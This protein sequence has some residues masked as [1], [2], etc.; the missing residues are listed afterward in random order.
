MARRVTATRR[1]ADGQEERDEWV[2]REARYDLFLNGERLLG[3]N[4]LPCDLE[5]YVIGFLANEGILECPYYLDLAIDPQAGRIE[6]RGPFLKSAVRDFQA[7]RTL[8]SG[9]G[10]GQTGIDRDDPGSVIQVESDFAIPRQTVSDVM[11]RLQKESTLY[12]LTGGAHIAALA[13]EQ[14]RLLF[15]AEDIGRHAA[16]DKVIGRAILAAVDPARCALF[17]SGRIASEISSKA[18]RAR[19]P[20]LVSRAA[21][22]DLAVEISRRHRITLIGFVRGERMNVYSV[23]ERVLG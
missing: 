9:C 8:T 5:A 17:C 20:V 22:T 14:G 7:K 16:V 2:V 3:L 6:A 12:R 19:T 11:S 18:V 13:N 1:N 15:T 23:P 4:C 21:P 10:S